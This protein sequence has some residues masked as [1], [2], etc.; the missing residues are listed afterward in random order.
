MRKL[1]VA[2]VVLVII[3]VAASL[4]LIPDKNEVVAVQARDAETIASGAVDV[5]AEYNQG[6]RTFPI[7][8][9]LADK[10]VGEGNRDAAIAL[11]EEFVKVNPENVNGRKKL[12]EQYQL[13]GR[14]EDYNKELELVAAAEPSRGAAG[15][16][17]GH[18]TRQPLE[19]GARGGG[20]LPR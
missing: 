5:E 16:D 19:P 12:A 6:R 9:G 4:F 10:R 20:G 18:E 7:V 14:Q 8:A 17:R 13:A 2:A 11:L 3:G 15:R 1:I